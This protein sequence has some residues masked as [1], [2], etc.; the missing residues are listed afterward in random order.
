MGNKWELLKGKISSGLPGF[1]SQLA[2][3]S[4]LGC[5]LSGSSTHECFSRLSSWD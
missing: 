4:D 2:A 5:L 1:P 3:E